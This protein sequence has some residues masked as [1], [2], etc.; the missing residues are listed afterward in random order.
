[1]TPSPIN[2]IFMQK[3]L[4]EHHMTLSQTAE[5]ALRAVLYLARQPNG[6]RVPAEVIAR[7]LDAPRNYLSKTLGVLAKSGVITSARGPT[8]GFRLEVPAEELTLARVVRPFRETNGSPVC[9]TGDRE[10]NAESP[11]ST[12]AQWSALQAEILAPM[13]RTTIADLLGR[14][15]LDGALPEAGAPSPATCTNNGGNGR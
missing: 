14:P 7:S 10:C 11:C 13:E 2:H 1:M 6:T 3:S 12:H 15:S 4:M 8:G 5:H 9:L